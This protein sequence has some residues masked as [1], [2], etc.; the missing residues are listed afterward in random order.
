MERFSVPLAQVELRELFMVRLVH[1]EQVAPREQ[2]G[3]LGQVG[4]L[5][6]REVT[7]LLAHQDRPVRAALR[8]VRVHMAHP[9]Q[10][11]R[12]QVGHRGM[13][14]LFM[15]HRERQEPRDQQVQVDQMV[16]REHPVLP[17]V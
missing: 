14:A 10:V 8:A 5:D 13:M 15:V 3:H 1:Q 7:E 9:V 6:L 2:V 4:L 11:D 16:H 17:A 12:V